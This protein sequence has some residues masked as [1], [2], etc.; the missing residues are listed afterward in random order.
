MSSN[1]SRTSVGGFYSPYA[2]PARQ[3]L[4]SSIQTA[5]KYIGS[6]ARTNKKAKE[7]IEWVNTTQ[8]DYAS[9]GD[10]WIDAWGTQHV[11]DMVK[12]I[13]SE[14]P[15]HGGAVIAEALEASLGV[16]AL[17]TGGSYS[18]PTQQT[19]PTDLGTAL[20]NNAATTKVS[21]SY[22]ARDQVVDTVIGTRATS[23]SINLT[24]G[25]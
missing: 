12:V 20:R 25:Q 16:Y 13:K 23:E 8:R 14:L 6:Q 10:T 17:N 18:K 15:D 22:E 21:S 9:S 1:I 7:F 2:S 24:K 19:T 3:E 4:N 5:I 11:K